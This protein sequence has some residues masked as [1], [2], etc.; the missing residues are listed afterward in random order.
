MDL[1]LE[2]PVGRGRGRRPARAVI[3]HDLALALGLDQR[4]AVAADAG[5]LRLDHAEQRAGRHRRVRRRAAGLQHL[6]AGERR[7]GVR[8]RHHPVLGVDRGPAGEMEIPHAKSLTFVVLLGLPGERGVTWHIHEGLGNALVYQGPMRDLQGFPGNRRLIDRR[9][10]LPRSPPSI[11]SP[12]LPD[13]R[14][15]REPLRAFCAGLGLKGSILLAAEGING[16]VAGS[17]DGIDALI[18]ELQQGALFGGRL[19][20]LELKFSR[21]TAMPFGRMKVRLKKEIVT[22]GDANADPTRQVGI[23]VEPARLECADRISRYDRDRHPQFLR[24]RDGHV[25]GRARS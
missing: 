22:L 25:R 21:A 2:V 19:D 23:Y 12:R 10:V 7:Q 20:H 5:R 11:N 24:S 9:H 3:G 4:K 17:D 16:T 1:A 8:G 15:L 14:E 13:F 18:A 6:D